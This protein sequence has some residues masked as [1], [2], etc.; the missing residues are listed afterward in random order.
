MPLE[1]FADWIFDEEIET[2]QEILDNLRDD[3]SAIKS[4]KTIRDSATFTTKRLIVIDSQG[5]TGKKKEI[6]SLPYKSIHMWSTENAGTIDLTSEVHLWTKVG[7]IK[8]NL[9]RNVDVRE[10]DQLLQGVCL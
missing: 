3:E 1:H 7:V 8:I 4:Y 6:Y 9:E 5:L 2:P 10:F